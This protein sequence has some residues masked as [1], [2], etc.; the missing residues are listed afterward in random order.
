[1]AD[2]TFIQVRVDEKLKQEAADILDSMGMDMPTA[3][4]MFLKKSLSSVG[5][6]LIRSYLRMNISQQNRRLRFQCKNIW[7]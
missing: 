4:R 5:F 7:T 6:R 2:Q 3:V 1:M